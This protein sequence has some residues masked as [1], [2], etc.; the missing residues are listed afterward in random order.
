MNNPLSPD[1]LGHPASL[2]QEDLLVL[3]QMRTFLNN[4]FHIE[5]PAGQVVGVIDT[6]GSG[7]SRFFL[8]NR[9]LQ[10]REA[11]G[12][13]VLGIEDTLNFGRDTFELTGENGE[14]LA[15]LRRRFTFL[16][17]QVDMHLAE[18]TKI[19]MHGNIFDFE[20]EFRIGEQVPARVSRQ[21][22]GLARGL[23]GRSSYVLSFAA[24]V[25][26]RLRAAI[27]GGV[28]TLDLMRA[29]DKRSGSS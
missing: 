9:S 22:S 24:D 27:I 3:H 14:P 7:T 1:E 29:K 16:R 15:H 13:P 19:E 18:G 5:T 10:V 12:R 2:L 4:D 8:G 23:L 17:R 25:P 20:F 26:P 21:W 28:V 11:D 6:G